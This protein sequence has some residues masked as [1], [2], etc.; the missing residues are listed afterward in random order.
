MGKTI[1]VHS[2]GEIK[3]DNVIRFIRKCVQT[4]IDPNSLVFDLEMGSNGYK[5]IYITCVSDFPAESL[6]K[7]INGQSIDDEVLIAKV[8]TLIDDEFGLMPESADYVQPN[9]TYVF[10]PSRNKPQIVVKSEPLKETVTKVADDRFIRKER[11]PSRNRYESPPR[12]S[13][14]ERRDSK[15]SEKRK[16][17]HSRRHRHHE[18]SDSSY[19][20]SDSPSTIE[21]SKSRHRHH[22]RSRSSRH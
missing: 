9:S 17:S 13:K 7:C 15:S 12:K 6:Q 21:S 4:V 8:I 19:S 1:L 18:S 11:E 10:N 3:P 2:F 16:S 22:S 5:V 14:E 20:S